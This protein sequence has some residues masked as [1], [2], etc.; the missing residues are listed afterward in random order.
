LGKAGLG[1][2]TDQ[3]VPGRHAFLLSDCQGQKSR[4]DGQKQR[5]DGEENK[6]GAIDGFLLIFGGPSLI[7]ALDAATTVA[8]GCRFRYRRGSL[9]VSDLT[10]GSTRPRVLFPRPYPIRPGKRRWIPR[11]HVH[12]LR[13]QG[14]CLF[15][16]PWDAV[17]AGPLAKGL[18]ARIGPG[19]IAFQETIVSTLHFFF[20]KTLPSIEPV[21]LATHA[22]PT[23]SR[24]SW[25]SCPSHRCP[26]ASCASPISRRQST[27]DYNR[28]FPTPNTR[29]RLTARAPSCCTWTR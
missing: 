13:L 22:S 15:G 29:K 4:M 2:W 3:L 6:H 7:Q 5:L 10:V 20:I 14:L 25:P 21:D 16:T 1:F 11:L 18:L 12:R 24:R 17:S 23:S 8:S 19:A 9:S 27:G 28:Q 26:Q